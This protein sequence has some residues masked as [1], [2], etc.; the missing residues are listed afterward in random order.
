MAEEK[1]LERLEGFVAT[2]LEKF[3]ILR[4]DHR[5]LTERLQRRDASIENLQNELAALKNDQ[6]E[7]SS[8]VNSLIDQIEEWEFSNI[9]EDEEAESYNSA[10]RTE[11]YDAVANE[12][13]NDSAV[14]ENH[15]N[16]DNNG[17]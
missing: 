15:Y 2:L 7:V 9:V 3:N 16:A 14:Q 13:T 4:A 5:E 8:R 11:S 1:E 6:S 17:E 10:E 12:E